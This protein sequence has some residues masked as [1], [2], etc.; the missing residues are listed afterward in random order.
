MFQTGLEFASGTTNDC[1][2]LVAKLFP[3]GEI[4]GAYRQ[5]RSALGTGDLVL[6]T[7]EADPSGF[8]AMPRVEYVKKIKGA[9]GHLARKTLPALGI[10]QR[11][12]H[13]V[14][15]LPFESDA[16]W[17]VVVRGQEIPVMCVIFAIPHEVG[18]GAN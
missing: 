18:V 14:A 5:A 15:Q 11:S 10:A 4:L 16:M 1:K 3:P 8:Q 9:M 6:V 2:R 12:A 13:G 17:L 7:E